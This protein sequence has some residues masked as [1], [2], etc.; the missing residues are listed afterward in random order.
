MDNATDFYELLGVSRG[1][2]ADEIKKAYRKAARK[3]H[4][5]VNPGDKAS[6]ERYKRISQAYEVL[7][8]PEKRSK[9][10]QYGQAWQQAQQSGSWQ[11]GDFGDFV[12]T[13]FGAGSFE[14]IFGSLFG[15]LRRGTGRQRTRVERGPERGQTISHELPIS[16]ADAVRGGEKGL[17]LSIADRCPECD[18]LG[19]KS[20][21]CPACG[22]TG[23][24]MRST[25]LFGFGGACPQCQGAGQVIT[26]QC[27]KCRGGGEVL[28]ER[29]LKVRIPAG[30][31][32]GSKIRLAGEGARGVRGGA[33]GDLI[34]VMKVED[35][36]FF[37]RVGDD[38][39][40]EVP[41]SFTE[42]ALGARI[43]VP[44]VE[45]SVAL[46]IPPGTKSG[47]RFRLKGQG[48]VLPATKSRSDQ[49]VTVAILPP[50]RLSK[51][52]RE[53]LEELQRVTEEDPRAD[54]PQGL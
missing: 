20:Q 26:A 38:I 17:T 31:K 1:A 54:L 11:G 19:G 13:N 44:T 24:S 52:Q 18:G 40:V 46:R 5:D 50:R 51:E 9:Y 43:S 37:R 12:Y 49:F 35:H 4:P 2:S 3:Y 45:G 21:T 36:P 7:S 16:F 34:L 25:G 27:P 15:D 14:D 22:G 30:V 42:A 28:R 29:R 6:E 47:Q 39:E 10:D 41:I 32:S 23:Q 53:L 8:D 33:D 48:T